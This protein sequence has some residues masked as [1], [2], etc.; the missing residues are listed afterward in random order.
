MYV[1]SSSSP[2]QIAFQQFK[3]EWNELDVLEFPGNNVGVSGWVW[4]RSSFTFSP[5]EQRKCLSPLLFLT[6]FRSI[7]PPAPAYC[8]LSVQT[9]EQS[10]WVKDEMPAGRLYK[11]ESGPAEIS[12]IAL[13]LNSFPKMTSTKYF[14]ILSSESIAYMYI[15]T[16]YEIMQSSA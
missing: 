14:H 15:C 1:E 13:P 2:F 3:R 16:Y 7:I 6:P 4:W 12:K 11:K 8:L 10:S 5:Q 9:T